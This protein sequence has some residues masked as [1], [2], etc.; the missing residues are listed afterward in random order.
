LF[1]GRGKEKSHADL[2]VV[3]GGADPHHHNPGTALALETCETMEVAD[4]TG[5]R[6]AVVVVRSAATH[7]PAA[8][9]VLALSGRTSLMAPRRPA[10]SA[11]DRVVGQNKVVWP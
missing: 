8:G 1:H 5:T 10:A 3:I 6:L 7:H 4:G 2:V 11:L 9:A